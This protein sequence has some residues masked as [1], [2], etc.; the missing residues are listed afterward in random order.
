MALIF[1][2][3]DFPVFELLFIVSILLIVGF[4]ALIIAVIYMLKELRLMKALIQE[5]RIVIQE[6]KIDLQK[7]EADL[8][9]LE[10]LEG[11]KETKED[12][13]KKYIQQ[14]LQKGVQ[15]D[16]I[17]KTLL[18]KGWDNATLEKLRAEIK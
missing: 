11:K 16:H 4:V 17:K 5:E 13:T 9:E 18:S 7:F 10:A 2:G 3:I 8:K 14:W 6:E 15:W 12:A 1:G